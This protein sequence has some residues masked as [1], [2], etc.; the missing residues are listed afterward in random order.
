MSQFLT[1][2]AF[3]GSCRAL[4]GRSDE[5]VRAYAGVVNSLFTD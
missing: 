2:R 1:T 3:D 4:P 5:G